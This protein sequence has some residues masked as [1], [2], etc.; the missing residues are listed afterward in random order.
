MNISR[1]SL[2]LSA[3][4]GLLASEAHGQIDRGSLGDISGVAGRPEPLGPVLRR[5]NVASLKQIRR[6]QLP[7][8]LTAAA[9]R[10]PD[11]DVIRL[12]NEAALP[13]PNPTL[14]RIRSRDISITFQLAQPAVTWWKAIK[15]V[16]F[17]ARDG[18]LVNM[19]DLPIRKF[20]EKELDGSNRRVNFRIKEWDLFSN[21]VNSDRLGG[22]IFSKAKVLGAHTDMYFLDGVELASFGGRILNI[23]WEKD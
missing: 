13:P 12:I 20:T 15:I 17:Q 1:R 7:D 11:G 4:G 6:S 8:S 3:G 22:I 16:T 9:I 14:P 5:I 23:I 18:E 19:N 2:L 10:L 21:G